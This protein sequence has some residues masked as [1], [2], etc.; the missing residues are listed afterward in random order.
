MPARRPRRT[1]PRSTGWVA[2]GPAEQIFGKAVAIEFAVLE[3]EPVAPVAAE[4]RCGDV[5]RNRHLVAGRVASP[6]DRPHQRI[7]RL[8]VRGKRRPPAALVGHAAQQAAPGH[9]RAG[10][11][12]DFG[13][14]L[15]RFAESLPA[16]GDITMKSWM[17]TRRPACAPPPKIWISGSGRR[18]APSPASMAPQRQLAAGGGG[19][20]NRQRSRDDGVA[21]EPL[22]GRRAVERDQRRVDRRLIERV[23]RRQ[24][25]RDL[26][27]HARERALNVKAA[28]RAPPSRCSTA[29]RVPREA[30][31]GAT[32]R[33]TAPSLSGPPPRWSGGRA[34]P[35]CGGR[36]PIG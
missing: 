24:R 33:P 9:D 12:I 34:N 4:L 31:A 15:E 29:S 17:S 32:P 6:L 10:G 2:R 7:K 8:L 23:A 16:L 22:L 26:V 1:G 20:Q 14:D 30:P 27:T 21:A 3:R 5:E 19:V 25:R 36:G 13:R 35:R 28:E 11:V 18:T